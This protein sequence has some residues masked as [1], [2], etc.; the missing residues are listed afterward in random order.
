[1]GNHSLWL[2]NHSRL[3]LYGIVEAFI[4]G[5]MLEIDKNYERKVDFCIENQ[6]GII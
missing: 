6:R 5:C 1:M 3:F 2:E 4:K